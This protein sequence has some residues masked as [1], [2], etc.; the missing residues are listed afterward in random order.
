MRGGTFSCS[1]H[2]HAPSHPGAEALATTRLTR[3]DLQGYQGYRSCHSFQQSPVSK[4]NHIPSLCSFSTGTSTTGISIR[5]K[6]DLIHKNFAYGQCEICM[7]LGQSDHSVCFCMSDTWA[8]LKRLCK[9]DTGPD[10]SGQLSQAKYP[11][12]DL[13]AVFSLTLASPDCSF[14]SFQRGTK[15]RL[16]M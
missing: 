11:S 5:H 8:L 16:L 13:M 2:S 10:R 3:W 1:R 4:H 15:S 6:A 12:T 7:C 14:L 9:I